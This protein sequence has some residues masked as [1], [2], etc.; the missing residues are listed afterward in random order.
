M[1]HIIIKKIKT[2]KESLQVLTINNDLQFFEIQERLFKHLTLSLIDLSNNG[3]RDVSFITH[4]E[5]DAII[6]AQNPLQLENNILSTASNISFVQS[7]L[8]MMSDVNF[9]LFTNLRHLDLSGN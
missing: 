7:Q 3:L 4:L 2:L 9:S 1:Q 6:L 8:Q 5:A